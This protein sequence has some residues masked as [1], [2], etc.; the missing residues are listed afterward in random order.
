MPTKD[1]APFSYISPQ[2]TLFSTIKYK[3]SIEFLSAKLNKRVKSQKT[4][5]NGP[6]HGPCYRA[7]AKISFIIAIQP[8]HWC[9][10]N[11]RK[12]ISPLL[13]RLGLVLRLWSV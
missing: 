8:F 3:L 6:T 9:R 4:E 12:K 10:Q 1:L 2:K 11:A 13:C 7:S 5:K